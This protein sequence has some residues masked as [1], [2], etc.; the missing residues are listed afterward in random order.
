MGLLV[1]SKKPF[2][3]QK[4]AR[5]VAHLCCHLKHMNFTYSIIEFRNFG[6]FRNFTILG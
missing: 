1:K 5:V 2:R 6:G 3:T 4:Y